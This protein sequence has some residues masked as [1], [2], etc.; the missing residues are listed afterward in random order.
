MSSKASA[1]VLLILEAFTRFLEELLLLQLQSSSTVE[2]LSALI[3]ARHFPVKILLTLIEPAV[4]WI[5]HRYNA[6]DQPNAENKFMK[7][8]AL[9]EILLIRPIGEG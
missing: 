4:Q 8:K 5:N 9:H 2:Q 1:G 3:L 6:I 7:K